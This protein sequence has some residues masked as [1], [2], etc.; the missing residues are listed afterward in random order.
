VVQQ[1]CL[2]S[3][4]EAGQDGDGQ[5]LHGGR[6]AFLEGWGDSLDRACRVIV[7]YVIT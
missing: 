3:A 5:F 4:E 2:S 6:T 1:S 7:C